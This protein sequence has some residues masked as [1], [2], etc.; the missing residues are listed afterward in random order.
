MD[1]SFYVLAHD[2][3]VKLNIQSPVI[4]SLERLFK[5]KILGH[6]K[7]IQRVAPKYTFN[8]TRVN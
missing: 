5:K 4:K 1:F 2:Y 7:H 6:N 3:F 8:L